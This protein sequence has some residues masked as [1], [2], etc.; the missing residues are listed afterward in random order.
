MAGEVCGGR[1]YKNR[2]C[3]LFVLYARLFL[4]IDSINLQHVCLHNVNVIE[5]C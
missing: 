4:M 2:V 1:V 5:I 3:E